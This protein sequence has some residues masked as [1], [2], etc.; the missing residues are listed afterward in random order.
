MNQLPVNTAFELNPLD[1]I[2]KV[3]RA[4]LRKKLFSPRR[5]AG[6]R[7]EAPEP[8][9]KRVVARKPPPKTTNGLVAMMIRHGATQTEI[10][11]KTGVSRKKIR[12]MARRLGYPTEL[13]PTC[14]SHAE[15][16]KALVDQGLSAR[17][18]SLELGINAGAV[19]KF[20]RKNGWREKVIRPP[21]DSHADEIRKLYEQGESF[22]SIGRAIGWDKKSVTRF[23]RENGRG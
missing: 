13:R 20:I 23:I 4:T 19:I 9:V 18:I 1:L 8:A 6:K 21:I 7:V 10:Q 15:E 14:A 5:D 16:I 12:E 22:R 3:D 17:R 11:Q 2:P